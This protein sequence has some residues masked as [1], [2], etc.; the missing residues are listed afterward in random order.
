MTRLTSRFLIDLILRRT[1]A[2]GGFAAVLASGDDQSGTILIQC[3]DR[4]HP[5]PLLERRFSADG[6]YIWEAVGPGDPSDSEART[7]YQD[8]RR[9]ADPDLWIVELDIADAPRL[10]AEWAALT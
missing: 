6:R 1:Q 3:S 4:G 5:G 9:K 2:A 10:V 7:D 8:R